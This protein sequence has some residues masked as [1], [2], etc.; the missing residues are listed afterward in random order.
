M[1]DLSG[2]LRLVLYETNI[3]FVLMCYNIDNVHFL[4]NGKI[5][6]DPNN[7]QEGFLY[8]SEHVI[9]DYG[10]VQTPEPKFI[11]SF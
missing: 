5:H 11:F 2:C 9:Y 8:N 4:D 6:W 10:R 3:V 1:L 7:P